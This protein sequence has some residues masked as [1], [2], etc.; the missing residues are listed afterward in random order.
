MVIAKKEKTPDGGKDEN[1]FDIQQGVA[2]AFFIKYKKGKS[3]SFSHSE[4]FGLREVKYDWLNKHTIKNTK[5][6]K[7]VPH[8]EFYQFIPTDNK[9]ANHYYS[10]NKITDIFPVN[11]VGIFT[12]RDSLTIGWNEDEIWDRVRNF[13]R[14]ETELARQTYNLGVDSTD[15]KVEMAQKDIKDSGVIKKNL[16]QI[17]YRPFDIRFTYYTGKSNDFHCRPRF[18]IMRHMLDG[19]LALCVGRQGS[20]TGS[21]NYD[22]VFVS[23]NIVDLNLFRRGGELVFP[24]YLYQKNRIKEKIWLYSANDV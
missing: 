16:T 8:P 4:L 7:V 22:I 23:E 13:A 9:L 5:W 11:S 20:V 1:V 17:L 12:A 24:L 15:W 18:E 14:L 10:F 19:N 21:N 3:K 2:I 6:T